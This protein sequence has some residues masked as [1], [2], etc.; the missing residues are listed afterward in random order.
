MPTI[1]PLKQPG[2]EYPQSQTNILPKLHVRALVLA[3]GSGGKSTMITRLLV[4][5]QFYGQ[6]FSRIYWLSPSATVDD[7]LDPLREYVNKLQ[8]QEEDPTFHDD[9]DPA[10]TRKLLDRQKK[11]TEHLKRRGSKKRF[12]IA[13]VVDDHADNP[14]AMHRA[15]GILETLYV[16]ARHFGVSTIV[17]SQKLK[18]M[19]PTVR[20]N[21]TALF[22]FRLRNHSDLL[23]GVIR[24]YS[25]LVDAK[26]LLAMYR[27]AVERPF[28]FLYID[29]LA[30]N[31][32][33]MFYSSFLSRFVPSQLTN[34]LGS[35]GG[36]E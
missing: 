5:K 31:I 16:G 12:N 22:I 34:S 21:L 30:K 14:A 19:S 24:E 33:N 23:D 25:A 20:V 8:D 3:P 10:F 35:A 32:D 26:T 13:I 7:S 15:G 1:E 29:L 11:I 2:Y 17:S 27:A 9:F 4:D 36:I 18:L 28:G 6:K